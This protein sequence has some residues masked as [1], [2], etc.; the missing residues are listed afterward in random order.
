MTDDGSPD[1]GNRETSR[2]GSV[3][4]FGPSPLLEVSIDGDE[5]DVSA[6]S[7]VPGGQPVWVA[8]MA[9]TMGAAVCMCGLSGGRE[10]A[11]LDPLLAAEPFECRLV[12]TTQQSGCFVVDQRSEPARELAAAW[13]P[14]PC[15]EEVEHLLAATKKAAA[16]ADVLVVT[17]PMP[18]DA[19]ALD[20]YTRLVAWAAEHRL[21]VV[22]DLSTPRL[23]AALRGGA[24]HV[25]VNDWELAEAVTAPV[26]EPRQWH[27]AA[28][29]LIERG[30]TS[31]VVTR[32]P[33]SVH[34]V[35]PDGRWLDIDPP[36]VG[37]GRAAG[38]GDA[39]TGAFAA[40]LAQGLPWLDAVVLGMGAGAAH[41]SGRGESS[42]A[43]ITSLARQ[44]RVREVP[45]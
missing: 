1:G 35:A 25:K 31:V 18:G 32:G 12:T 28:R 44:V 3:V 33:Q 6:I 43:A 26:D 29:H 15:D 42:A 16:E 17:N 40:A 7:I 19:L 36:V 8:R 22:V 13:A 39:W 30:A 11:V 37:P 38:C 27:R 5:T 34:A 14:P 41:Y 9:A 23:E 2:S 45:A 10:A 4:V 20:V 21:P 24:V